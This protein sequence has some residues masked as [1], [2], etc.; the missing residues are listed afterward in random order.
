MKFLAG[1]QNTQNYIST[2]GPN[3]LSFAT[4]MYTVICK[5]QQDNES[6]DTANIVRV[7]FEEKNWM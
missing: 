5:F 6:I 3:F 4:E 7:F 1:N 2:W